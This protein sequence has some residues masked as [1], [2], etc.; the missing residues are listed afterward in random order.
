MQPTLTIA[1]PTFNRKE[2]LKK[3]IENVLK[4][5]VTNEVEILVSKVSIEESRIT[6]SLINN[7][8]PNKMVVHKKTKKG[9]KKNGRR[10]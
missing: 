8:K 6:F 7:K 10:K 1:I 2:K 9:G 3:C 5:I 4:Q